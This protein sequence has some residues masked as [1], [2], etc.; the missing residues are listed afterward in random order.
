MVFL[1][2][3][4]HVSRAHIFFLLG[5]SVLQVEFVQSKLVWHHY[6]NVIRHF[7][8]N[9]VMAADGLQPPDLVLILE[10]N[11]I[12]LVGS[13]L[14][15]NAA[16]SLH[17]LSRAVDVWQN[18]GNNIFLSDSSGYLFFSIF[19][20]LINHQRVCSKHTGIGGDGLRG[21]HAYIGLID[22]ACRPHA[23]S[24]YR[25]WHRGV[26]HWIVRKVDLHMGNYGFIFS[27]LFLWV[28]YHEFFRCIMSGSGIVISC[29]HGGAIIRRIFS[30]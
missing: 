19:C 14:L 29:N 22:A 25:I 11:S 8:C 15:Q 5:K 10:G 13:V 23:F 24:C 6:V 21:S 26:A 2:K 9:P 28:N 20:R 3:F 30:N 12:H 1:Y 17:S 16:K 7:S 27:R 4:P 18:Q